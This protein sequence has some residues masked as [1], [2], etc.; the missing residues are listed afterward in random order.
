MD[1]HPDRTAAIV[2]VAAIL[3]DAPDVATFWDNV[4]DGRY[5]ISD[6]S[7]ER[8]DPALYYDPD[9]Q[10]ARQDVLEDRRLGTRLRVES[11]RVEAPDPAARRRLHG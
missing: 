7:P 11:T 10:R 4:K 3:P 6:V 1:E 5:C 2:G 9:P 8:W